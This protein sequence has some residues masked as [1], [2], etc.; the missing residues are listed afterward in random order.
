EAAVEEYPDDA[1]IKAYYGSSISLASRYAGDANDMFAGAIKG[2]KQIDEAVKIAPDSVEVR[3]VR[4]RHGL[5]LLNSFSGAPPSPSSTS[6]TCG[7]G[8]TKGASSYPS[9]SGS[10]SSGCWGAP[11][12]GSI[13]STK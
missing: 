8:T 6:S 2:M 5:R 13:S 3:F 10:N 4:A 12:F 11:I 1:L 9:K 7:T